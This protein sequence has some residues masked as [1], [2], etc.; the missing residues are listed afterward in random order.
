MN[1]IANVENSKKKKHDNKIIMFIQNYCKH[2]HTQSLSL[3]LSLSLSFSHYFS[4]FP[5]YRRFI[6]KKS[7]IGVCV[8]ACI[9]KRKLFVKRNG[10]V[11][12]YI[13]LYITHFLPK[14]NI[15]F[16]CFMLAPSRKTKRLQECNLIICFVSFS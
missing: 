1:N 15:I 2:T 3:S 13:Y 8:C 5:Y 6:T 11:Y 4:F 7:F 16:Y 14:S 9:Y 12:N 10:L